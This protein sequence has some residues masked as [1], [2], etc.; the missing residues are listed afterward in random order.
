MSTELPL[1]SGTPHALTMEFSQGDV[2]AAKVMVKHLVARGAM[3]GPT[4]LLALPDWIIDDWFNQ[5]AVRYL[6]EQKARR[7]QPIAVIP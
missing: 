5:A 6:R 3:K 4:D 2:M 1:I 7:Q